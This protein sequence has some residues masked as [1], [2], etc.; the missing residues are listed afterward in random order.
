MS[1]YTL[2][3]TGDERELLLE[4]LALHHEDMMD[5]FMS[6]RKRTSRAAV[7]ESAN[8]LAV[9]FLQTTDAMADKI[10]SLKAD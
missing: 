10:R 3:L 8:E 1:N 6:I 2:P 5:K 9:A 7:I 4:V